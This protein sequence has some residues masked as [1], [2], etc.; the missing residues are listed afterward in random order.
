MSFKAG[1]FKEMGG[2]VAWHHPPPAQGW[3]NNSHHIRDLQRSSVLRG[4]AGCLLG[5]KTSQNIPRR[6]WGDRQF[7]WWS[8]RKGLRNRKGE[9]YGLPVPYEEIVQMMRTSWDSWVSWVT[10]TNKDTGWF[11]PGDF[12]G[13][14]WWELWKPRGREVGFF[15][16]VRSLEG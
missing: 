7:G 4:K 15:P 1:V 10:E 12:L 3:Q 14:W 13:R 6:H 16:E 5:A 2:R 11:T 8:G 9:R